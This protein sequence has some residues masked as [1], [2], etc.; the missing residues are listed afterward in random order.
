VEIFGIILFMN[1]CIF[2]Y[3]TYSFIQYRKREKYRTQ[4][5]NHRVQCMLDQMERDY[6]A[7]LLE[8][9]E[10]VTNIFR[11]HVIEE[12]SRHRLVYDEKTGKYIKLRQVE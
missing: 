3:F 9:E 5:L 8:E 11:E 7:S 6:Q 4:E 12:I 2:G 10:P 1:L